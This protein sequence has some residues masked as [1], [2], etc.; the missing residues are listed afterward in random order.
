MSRLLLGVMYEK[1]L[2]LIVDRKRMRMV[3]DLKLVAMA[4]KSS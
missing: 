4:V 1:R 2:K 3:R